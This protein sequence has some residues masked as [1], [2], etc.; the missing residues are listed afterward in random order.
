M[1]LTGAEREYVWR[2][3]SNF[4]S[5]PRMNY[6][7]IAKKISRFPVDELD[8]IFHREVSPVCGWIFTTGALI[9]VYVFDD[10]EVVSDIKSMLAA[11]ERS[12]LARWF[13]DTKAVYYR[14]RLA[15]VWREVEAALIKAR[16]M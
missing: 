6:E 7:L 3:M 5:D 1:K 15:G 4:F 11:K 10:D 12:L 14:H 13:Y 8:F 2:V 9:N 16:Q